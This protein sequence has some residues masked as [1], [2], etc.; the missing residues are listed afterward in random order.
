[1]LRMAKGSLWVAA[2]AF[3]VLG[4][5]A[6]IAP[7]WASQNFP[8]SVGPFLAMTI[9]GWSIGTGLFAADAAR[10]LHRERIYPLVTYLAFFGLGQAVVVLAF[11]DRLRL[12][13]ILTWPYLLGLATALAGSVAAAVAWRQASPDREGSAAPDRDR[14]AAPAPVPGWARGVVLL[15]A[16]FVGILALGTA[17]AGAEGAIAQGR[18]FPE[19]MSPFS[20]RAFA[21]FLFALAVSSASLLVARQALSYF[22]LARAGLYLIVP[23]TVAALLNLGL[24]TLER[25][26]TIFYLATYVVVGLG[27]A[28]VLWAQRDLTR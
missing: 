23:I 14:L 1:M 8:W 10:D 13:A 19:T 2:V 12:D 24:F 5:A 25:P 3:L 16:V 28:W 6:W 27:L 9:G 7:G 18:V 4:L 17:I 21:A 20:M 11:A 26:L 22:E 15:F